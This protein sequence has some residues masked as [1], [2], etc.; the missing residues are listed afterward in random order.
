MDSALLGQ[1]GIDT[2]IVGPTGDGL[3]ADAEWVVVESIP[4]LAQILQHSAIAFCGMGR[5]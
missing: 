2:V 5:E 3:H 1:A 4:Q